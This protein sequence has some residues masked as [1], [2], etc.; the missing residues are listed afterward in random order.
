MWRLEEPRVWVP[1]ALLL[2]GALGLL[3]FL[4]TRPSVATQRREPPAPLVRAIE[5]VPQTVRLSVH[6]HGTVE[7][8]TESDL[9][10]EVSG[11][12][13]WVSPAMATGGFFE[14]DQVLL[15]LDP[16]DARIG[17]ER[18]RAALVR[19]ESQRALAAR[20][21][22]RLLGLAES[23]VVSAA[24]LDDAQHAD[25]A[26][27]ASLR[28]ARA[29]LAVAERDL[30]H[31]ELRAPFTGRVRSE[32]VDVGQFAS[33]GSAIARLYAIDYAELRLPVP[34][35]EL[36]NLE[37]PAYY[38]G[39]QVARGPDVVIQGELAG[40]RWTWRGYVVRT[41]GEIDPHTRM[42][43]VVARVDDPYARHSS[44]R[45]PLPMGLFVDAEIVGR[46]VSGAVVLPRAA[47]RDAKHVLVV[48]AEHRLHFRQVE[49][50][51]A[52]QD[53]VVIGKGLEGGERVCTSPLDAV[54]DGMRVRLAGEP[55]RTV[56]PAVAGGAP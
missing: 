2:L 40:Q 14:A 18:A 8:R 16:E 38:R 46:E 7:P 27:E 50:L 45:T 25:R 31:T 44:E 10:P 19:A 17:R 53:E 6:T 48:D 34:D 1:L 15:R 32:S 33:R 4:V 5:V 29:Q 12:V 56:Q 55:E 26:A 21:L 47:L 43:R 11:R 28:E 52:T 9:V 23:E 22:E 39:E 3:L 35:H 54:V 37:L 36:G 42:L 20:D 51:R 24:Q 30:A 13:I 49:V 41:E